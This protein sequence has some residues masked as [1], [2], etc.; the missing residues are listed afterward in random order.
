MSLT[1]LHCQH[2]AFTKLWT[3]LIQH[4]VD[5]INIAV[6][7][8]VTFRMSREHCELVIGIGGRRSSLYKGIVYS[9]MEISARTSAILF[10][11]LMITR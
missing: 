2:Q 9:R 8:H 11:Q 6:D 1:W 4:Q 5:D 3:E 7:S 10:P